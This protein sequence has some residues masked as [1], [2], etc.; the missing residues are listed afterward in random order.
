LAIKN[1]KSCYL[2]FVFLYKFL[3]CRYELAIDKELSPFSEIVNRNFKKWVFEKNAGNVHFSDEQMEW[4]RMI[5]DHIIT[6]FKITPESFDFTPFDAL[7]GIGKF[8]QL[9]GQNYGYIINEL[10]EVLVA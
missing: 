1:L 6:S 2:I 9:F 10:N 8:F 4:L 3:K 5:K 7:G